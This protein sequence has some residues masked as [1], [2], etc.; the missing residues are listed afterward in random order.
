MTQEQKNKCHRIIHT[1]AVAAGAGNLLPIPGSGFAADTVA[2]TTMA[3]GL[4][5]VFG[6]DLSEAAAKALAI[7]AIKKEIMKRPLKTIG[8]EIA[9]VIPGGGNVASAAISVAMAEAA[10]WS[11]AKDFDKE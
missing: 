11:M 1:G 9:K 2:L 8:K 6:K 3:C 5:T 7:S 4:A 10:G